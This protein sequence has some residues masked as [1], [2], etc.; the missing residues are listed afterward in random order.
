MAV[1]LKV[2]FFL[3]HRDWFVG[4]LLTATLTHNHDTT[5]LVSLV[6]ACECVQASV[7]RDNESRK[8]C[9]ENDTNED[10]S[11]EG[12]V[13]VGT[14]LRPPKCRKQQQQ[15]RHWRS[16]ITKNKY[17]FRFVPFSLSLIAQVCV[18]ECVCCLWLVD[19]CARAYG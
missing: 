3:F 6:C 15:R 2:F 12:I 11:E 17:P 14:V 5:H 8:K 10:I 1:F 19:M 7:T 9:H 16:N 4:Y 18:C 13:H